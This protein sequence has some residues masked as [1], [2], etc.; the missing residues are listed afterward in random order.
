MCILPLKCCFV[1]VSDL[2]FS[3]YAGYVLRKSRK[4]L[5]SLSVLKCKQMCNLP[6]LILARYYTKQCSK[7]L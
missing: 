2:N 6:A 1:V 4:N 5:V 7:G 3:I